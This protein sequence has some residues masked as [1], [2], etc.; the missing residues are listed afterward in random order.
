M[1]ARKQ[2]DNLEQMTKFGVKKWV[3][4]DE[5]AKLYSMGIAT[6][7]QLA[8]EA[9]AVYHIRTGLV[10]INTEKLDEYLEVFRDNPNLF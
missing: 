2:F 3:R 1:H 9:H 8:Q 7:Q 6:F 4:Y 10:L 5:G